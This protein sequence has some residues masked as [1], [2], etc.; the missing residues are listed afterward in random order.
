M[1]GTGPK[2]RPTQDERLAQLSALGFTDSQLWSQPIEHFAHAQQWRERWYNSPL[3][4]ASD[5]VVLRQSARPD[6]TR[7]Q[8]KPPNWAAA[9]K[10]PYAQ[11]LSEVRKVTFNVGR[12][13]RITP[14]LELSPVRLDDRQIKRIS[15]GSLQRWQ[16]LDIRPGDHVAISLAGMTIPRLDS[17]ALRASQRLEVTPP[18][19]DNFHTLSLLATCDRLRKPVFGP[20][21]LVKRQTSA[22]ITLR[23][24]RYLE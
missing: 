9:W 4:F 8:A 22:G 21:K 17:V 14:M 10:Y 6:A 13:G 11:V 12:T 15:A 3:P 2:A 23:G 1:C 18:N 24:P 16:A 20:L 7:W 19:P 5:G